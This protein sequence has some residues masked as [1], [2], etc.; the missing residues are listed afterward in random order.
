MST[1]EAVSGDA[2]PSRP[3]PPEAIRRLLEMERELQAQYA[4]DREVYK[5]EKRGEEL[6]PEEIESVARYRAQRA[7]RRRASRGA[8]GFSLA[9]QLDAFVYL[10]FAIAF[11]FALKYEYKIDLLPMAVDWLKPQF[12][13]LND[14]GTWR[15]RHSEEL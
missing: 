11:Y 5:K 12:D 14:D 3:P 13:H 4:D 7:K 15:G 1:E 10:C 9:C 2:P 6:S 8:N